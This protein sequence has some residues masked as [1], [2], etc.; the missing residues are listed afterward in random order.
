LNINNQ[1]EVGRWVQSLIDADNL[2]AFYVSD[3]WIKLRVDVLEE[4]KYECQRHKDLGFYKRANTVHHVQ[5]V[6]KYPHLAL[7]KVYVFEGKEY[8]NL[9]PLCHACHEEAHGYR[10][11]EKKKPLT[12]ER[13]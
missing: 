8:K 4:H 9:I 10:Q 2:H 12:E 1:D 7:S 11:K 13:W 6:R 3:P 5:Y